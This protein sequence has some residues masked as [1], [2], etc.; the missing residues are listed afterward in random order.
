MV[1]WTLGTPPSI[2]SSFQF[3]PTTWNTT[4]S[5]QHCCTYQALHKLTVTYS[6]ACSH[7]CGKKSTVHTSLHYTLHPAP[8]ALTHIVLL[9]CLTFAMALNVNTQHPTPGSNNTTRNSIEKGKLHTQYN[10]ELL[11]LMKHK[12]I[13]RLVLCKS[14]PTLLMFSVVLCYN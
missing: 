2:I 4:N 10:P 14:Q 6:K 9:P 12:E 1:N 13:E 5:Y 11:F 8:S 3:Q 7:V